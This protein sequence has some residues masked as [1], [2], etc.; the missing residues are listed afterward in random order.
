MDIDEDYFD[1]NHKQTKYYLTQFT[2]VAGS[3]KGTID[4]IGLGKLMEIIK[5]VELP[6][7]H[8]IKIMKEIDIDGNNSLN[9][10]EF[11]LAMKQ[12]KD[13][14][15][16]LKDVFI[17]LD[18]N[19]NCCLRPESIRHV[20][21]ALGENVSLK[22]IQEIIGEYDSSGEG[23]LNYGDFKHFFRGDNKAKNKR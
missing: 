6:R 3:E 12:F 15:D 2:K 16:L 22:E 14:E 8:L 10:N 18:K 23:K 17:A 21:M 19:S 13:N 11:V 7:E 5:G 1:I 20:M 4:I 9:Y